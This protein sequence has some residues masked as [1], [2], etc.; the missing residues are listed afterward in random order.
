MDEFHPMRHCSIIIPAYNESERISATLDKILFH[1][2]KAQWSAEILVVD[3]GSQDQTAAIVKQYADDYPAVTLYR[4]PH[5]GKG[6]AVAYGMMRARYSHLLLSDAD[7]PAPL[8]EANKL[9]AC[10]QTG[11][12]IA[13][14]SRWLDPR[15]QISRQPTFRRFLGRVFN[16]VVRAVLALTFVDTQCGFKL[17]TRSAAGQVFPRQ[18]IDGWAFDAEVLFIAKRLGLATVEVPIETYHDGRSKVRPL[19]DGFHMLLETLAIRWRVAQGQY[20]TPRMIP[21]WSQTEASGRAAFSPL[22]I[23]PAFFAMSAAVI[24][25]LVIGLFATVGQV[26]NSRPHEGSRS[27]GKSSPGALVSSANFP[28]A[29]DDD[30]DLSPDDATDGDSL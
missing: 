14:G 19:Q 10:L 11:A 3:D 12:D 7:L 20:T 23:R 15:L 5:R 27:L 18:Q 8:S 9:F 1:V 29:N 13:I 16:L 28:D 26:N 2:S 22:R 21:G 24:L 30:D 25:S 17:F 4:I 6:Y